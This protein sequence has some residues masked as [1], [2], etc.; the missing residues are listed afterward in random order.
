VGRIKRSAR[1]GA[2]IGSRQ[3]DTSPMTP[4]DPDSIPTE[5]TTDHAPPIANTF[6]SGPSQASWSPAADRGRG[7]RIG[8]VVTGLAIALTFSVGVGV[9]LVAAPVLGDVNG[10]T[11]GPANG[12]SGDA[13]ALIGEAWDILHRDYVGADELNDTTLA[14]GAI[15]GLTDAVGDTGHTSFLTPEE[16]AERSEDLSGSYVGIGVRIDAAEDGRPLIVSVFR[17]SPAEAAGLHIGDIIVAVDAQSTADHD[18]DAVASWIRGEAGSTVRVTVQAGVDGQPREVAIVRAEVAVET[19]SWSMVPGSTTAMLRLEQFSH[20]AADAVKAALED[21][22]AAG[23]DRLVFDLRGNPGGYV[24]EAVG[25]ASQFLSEGNVFI[26]RDASGKETVHPVSPD[27]SALDIPLV[28]LVDG[29][30][31]SSAEIVSGALQDAE[32]GDLIGVETFGTGT[33]LGEFVLR[34]GSALRVGTV[35]WLTPKGRRIWHEG[36]VPDITVELPDDARPVVPSDL[37]TM[38]P[39]QVGDLTDPQVARALSVVALISTP[40]S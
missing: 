22:K 3:H 13:F 25:V 30:T 23:A 9:G 10:T 32:R 7:P 14:Y 19:V 37:Q 26:E 27:G 28:V 29:G 12:A 8:R 39:A 34:D 16:R 15:E 40:A 1:S 4:T 2:R 36:I 24:D 33:V 6:A 38:T 18:L 17:D 11:P 35:E 20:G 5:P 31:A 21:I